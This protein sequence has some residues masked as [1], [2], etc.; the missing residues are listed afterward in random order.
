SG[1]RPCV[2]AKR[3]I[4]SKPAM[5]RSSRGLR[6]PFLSCG[7]KSASSAASSSRSRSL[8][9]PLFLE[10]HE[11]GRAFSH[12]PLPC[13]LLG[14]SW[15]PATFLLEPGRANGQF[16]RLVWRQAG[17]FGG[18]RRGDLFQAVLAHG[19]GE[20]GIG[21]AERIDPV[22]QVDV[23]F[24]HVHCEFAHAVDQGGVGAL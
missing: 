4:S 19:L 15:K 13:V 5:M 22:D 21:F 7:A 14:D 11:G 3:W 2:S 20:D 12:A 18:N 17:A 10:S 23:E 8:I 16:A 24:A 9:A 1:A 6:P